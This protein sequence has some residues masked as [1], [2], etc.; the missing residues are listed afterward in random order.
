MTCSVPSEEGNEPVHERRDPFATGL[1]EEE[2]VLLARIFFI[3]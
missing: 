3:F 2:D 1:D